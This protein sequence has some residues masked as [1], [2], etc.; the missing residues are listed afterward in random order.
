MAYHGDTSIFEMVRAQVAQEA[1]LAKASTKTG[2]SL[3]ASG[4]RRL[5]TFPLDLRIS[6]YLSI[7]VHL[8]RELSAVNES[9]CAACICESGSARNRG[10]C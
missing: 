9:G 7:V 4:A 10:T 3:L 2:G 1:R 6:V 5:R 8:Q